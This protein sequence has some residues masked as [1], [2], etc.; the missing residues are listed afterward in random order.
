MMCRTMPLI[1]FVTSVRSDINVELIIRKSFC[2]LS[3]QVGFIDFVMLEP[4]PNA[5]VSVVN[6]LK[7]DFQSKKF[8]R[9]NLKLFEGSLGVCAYV[10]DS[11]PD[12][13][14]SVY[15]EV[16]CVG[17]DC[18]ALGP[19]VE[20]YDLIVVYD[21]TYLV[22]LLRLVKFL[23]SSLRPGGIVRVRALN[24]EYG[25]IVYQYYAECIAYDKTIKR[26]CFRDLEFYRYFFS[27]GF[28]V[29]CLPLVVV[30]E[31]NFEVYFELT[32]IIG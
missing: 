30:S 13:V 19:C 32:K 4:S 27:V 18:F 11:V 29:R 26:M 28:H 23:E 25:T 2:R 9:V 8:D 6:S 1:N 7:V 12:C 14:S 15:P 22:D 5:N 21:Q 24:V 17:Y 16:V 10:S 3:D 20:Q 31:M